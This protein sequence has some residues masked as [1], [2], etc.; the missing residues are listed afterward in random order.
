[1][2]KG[3]LGV[4]G[5]MGPLASQ[6]FYQRV[7]DMTQATCDQ[8]NIPAVIL[9]DTQMPDR[10]VAIASGNTAPLEK[11]LLED[12]QLLETCGCT[13][14]AIPCNTSHAFVPRLQELIVTP[15]VNMIDE[16]ARALQKLGA[17]R[18]GILATDGTVKA[19][20]YHAACEKLGIEAVTPPPATQ[21]LVMSVIYD[22]IKRGEKGSRE[23]FVAID[24]VM[25]D[26]GC[27][28]AVLACTELSVYRLY[29]GLP[30]Y[31]VDAMDVLAKQA[32]LSCGYPLRSV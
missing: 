14:L 5:G 1:M 13:V 23:K 32:V 2:K 12:A 4:I 11:K 30:D 21:A 25:R 29:N 8:D 7:L 27:E 15:I 28:R 10:T 16:T 9:S 6:M 26:L 22:E 24:A 18:V 31:Y 17:G 3:K 20:L 19:G